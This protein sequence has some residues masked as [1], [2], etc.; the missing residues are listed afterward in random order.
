MT[1]S[2]LIIAGIIILNRG[3]NMI[4]K[5]QEKQIER[6]KEINQM[7]EA[8]QRDMQK[9][10]NESRLYICHNGT[11]CI[12]DKNKAYHVHGFFNDSGLI[13]YEIK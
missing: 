12:N 10:E 9:A 1:I 4:L 3:S 7:A 5:Y 13:A 6:Q 8:L 11:L 2:L